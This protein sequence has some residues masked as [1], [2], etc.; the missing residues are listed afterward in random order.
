M[1][2]LKSKIILFSI[3]LCLG[4]TLIVVSCFYNENSYF[5]TGYGSALTVISIF[6]IFKFIGL[7]KDKEKTKKYE[8]LQNE[9][10]LN[11]IYYKSQSL[12]FTATI[13][14]ESMATIITTLMGKI[15][16][17]EN[18]S[19][20]LLIQLAIYALAYSYYNKKY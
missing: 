12:V 19:Y 4:I 10:R 16:L 9:E 8:K 18:I 11:F 17:S 13:I 15:S 5:I 3:F 20:I 2:S 1:K 14:I 7:L 6:K